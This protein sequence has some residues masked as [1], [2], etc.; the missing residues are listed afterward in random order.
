M[1]NQDPF[2]R[3]S[4]GFCKKFL[5]RDRSLLALVVLLSFFEHCAL[6]LDLDMARFASTKATQA[7][8]LADAQT[9]KV[10]ELVWSF[11]D[12]VRVDDWE[13]AT[14]LFARLRTTR[15]MPG[16]PEAQASSHSLLTA[17][18]APIHETFA[19]YEIFRK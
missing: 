6:A 8:K 17:V 18:W 15:G 1:V 3:A 2:V 9:N 14:N 5:G 11:F 4:L 19:A 10:P 7:R 12:A 13:T 16:S